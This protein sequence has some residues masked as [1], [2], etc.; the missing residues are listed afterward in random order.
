ML[1]VYINFA[2]LEEGHRM[3]LSSS[4]RDTGII[5]CPWAALFGLANC[6]FSVVE[7]S[8][9]AAHCG[10]VMEMIK[11]STAVTYLFKS[12]WESRWDKFSCSLCIPMSECDAGGGMTFDGA[13]RNSGWW[14]IIPWMTSNAARFSRRIQPKVEEN[15]G[16]IDERSGC[17]L[18]RGLCVQ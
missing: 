4:W 15:A 17:E 14:V 13:G 16:W 6:P 1:P 8:R 3:D 7:S 10:H 5:W 12:T 11:R 18:Q 9:A 2:P